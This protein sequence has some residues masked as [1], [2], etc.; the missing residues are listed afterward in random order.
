MKNFVLIIILIV[1]AS[2]GLTLLISKFS[3]KK[4][5]KYI[6]SIVTFLLG[7]LLF[8]TAWANLDVFAS[9]GFALMGVISFASA[10]SGLITGVTIDYILP[11]IKGK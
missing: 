4:L 8:Y 2:V 5:Y 9:I 1:G 6:P 7:A 11:M 10:L 3:N